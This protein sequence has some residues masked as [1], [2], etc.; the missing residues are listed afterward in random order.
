M[1]EAVVP[2]AMP[3]RRPIHL[4]LVGIL[5]LLWNCFGAFDYTATEMRLGFYTKQFTAEQMAYVSS[6]PG[7]EVAAWALGVWGAL[8]GSIG[9]LLARRWAVWAFAVSLV[10]LAVSSL[11]MFGLSTVK[12]QGGQIGIMTAV[13]VIAILLQVY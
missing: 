6:L 12:V 10:G 11:Y 13:W 4:W 5:S 3:S 1:S 2:R 8:A 9:L 7:W